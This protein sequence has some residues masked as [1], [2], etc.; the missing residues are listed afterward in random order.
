MLALSGCQVANQP[1]P[2][3][4]AGKARS[5]RY[6][7]SGDV[8]TCRFE[9]RHDFERRPILS[10]ADHR[11][12]QGDGGFRIDM[13]QRFGCDEGDE[14]VIGLERGGELV[15]DGSFLKVAERHDREQ[16][17]PEQPGMEEFLR[18]P[19]S[20][21]SPGKF[22]QIF[23]GV[24]T[25]RLVAM[26]PEIEQDEVVAGREWRK[27]LRHFDHTF[28]QYRPPDFRDGASTPVFVVAY[29]SKQENAKEEK[30]YGGIDGNGRDGADAE[31]QV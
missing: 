27:R 12:D 2:D 14:R 4:R 15:P 17:A 21:R 22:F 9:D 23:P 1:R 8:R 13:Q 31:R 6:G 18:E 20:A 5:L 3:F 25:N 26:I 19:I 29:V 16:P 28:C 11:N 24:S 7:F 10:L 30:Q